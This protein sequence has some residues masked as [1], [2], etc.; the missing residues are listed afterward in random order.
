VAGDGGAR[1]YSEYVGRKVMLY[2]VDSRRKHDVGKVTF[3][4]KRGSD[5]GNWDLTKSDVWTCDFAS[6]TGTG[7]FRLAVEGI[8]CSP[9]F[10]LRRDVYYEPARTS[11]RGFFYMRI[12]MGKEFTPV[13]RQPRFIPGVEPV[14][15][16]VF[17]TTFGPLHPDWKTLSGDVWDKPDWSKY[18]EPGEPTNANAWGG[19]SDALDWDRHAG[20]VSIIYDLLL[21]YL[22]SNGKISHDD[23]GI[24]ESGNGIPDIIDEARYE[25]DFWQRLRDGQGGF[26]WGLNNPPGDHTTMYQAHASPVMAWVNAANTAMLADAFRIAGKADL[27]RRYRDA[28][29][30]AWKIADEKELDITLDVGNA[31]LRG[32]DFKMLAAACLYNLTGDRRY[33]NVVAQESII[34]GP[35]TEID[36]KDKLNQYWPTAMY[37]LCAK[38]RWQPINH[39]A[40]VANMK[41]SIL[42][43]AMQ[44]N[45]QPSTQRPSRRSSDTNYGWFQSTQIVHPL[46]IAHA[47][48]DD[49][50][51][52][53]TLLRALILEADYGLGRNPMNMVQMT[54]LG[55]RH[56]EDIYT[57]GRNDGT[58]GVHPG[59]TPYMNANAWSPGYMGDPQWLASRGYPAW[60]QWPHG[61]AL[62]RARYTY[63]NNEFTPQQSMRGKMLL[64]GYLYA[65]GDPHTAR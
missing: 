20:H 65:L 11:V 41:A 10:Q 31:R 60:E 6:F 32:R 23:M 54:G 9:E 28:A 2:D 34:T 16:R 30:E 53:N 47:I 62:W 35:T 4:K 14:N 57:S 45:V 24:A 49:A 17:R 38:N 12:G 39:P 43:E 46:C 58:P 56:A 42:H 25:V 27:M 63:A 33:E 61:E 22:L 36:Q 52:K 51:E 5:Y 40:L 48:S 21:P 13:P 19:H 44:K 50:T 3:W 26:S 8:G 29:L 37:L 1:D 64:L 7:R 55:S 59:H 18:K 15:F